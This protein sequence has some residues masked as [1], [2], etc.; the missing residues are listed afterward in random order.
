MKEQEIRASGLIEEYR[1]LTDVDALQYFD[2]RDK[3][4]AGMCG[5]RWDR[6]AA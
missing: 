6:G 1:R 4:V 2:E 3:A 5:L